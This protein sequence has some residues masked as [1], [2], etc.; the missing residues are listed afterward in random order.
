M[1][2]VYGDDG[3]DA[4]QERVVA[5]SALAGS[6][7]DWQELEARW[8]PRCDRIPFHAKDCESD[9]GDYRG[10]PHENNKAM[11]RDLVGILANSKICGIAISIDLTAQFQIFPDSAALSYY[12]AFVE[13]LQRTAA[14]AKRE[15]Q[16]AKLTF[17]ISSEN[18]FNAGY[19][20][21]AMREG[22]QSFREW[23]HPEISFVSAKYSARVQSGDLMAYEGWKALDHTVGPVK[24]VRK[25]WEALRGTGRFETYG[26]SAEWFK[27]L[28]DHIE[29]GDL[30]QRVKFTPQDYGMWLQKA[31]RQHNISNMFT[32]MDQ[33]RIRD[34]KEAGGPD[35]TKAK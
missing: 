33:M 28:R 14:M 23:L 10:I 22:D 29:S 9:Q 8:I 12:R 35:A 3:A 6:E 13:V 34:E 24:R 30:T 21:N 31:G 26:Y 4:K 18:E 5:V 32:F 15:G 20:Y 7:E 16:I 27:D 17:D 25:S 1:I 2:Y 19:L 11:Y